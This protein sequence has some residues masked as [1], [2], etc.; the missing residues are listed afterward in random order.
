MRVCGAVLL[1]LVAACYQQPSF[2]GTY[3]TIACS[4]LGANGGQCPS[5]LTCAAALGGLYCSPMGGDPCTAPPEDAAPTDGSNRTDAGRDA[6]TTGRFVSVSAGTGYACGLTA[7]GA[8]YCWGTNTNKIISSEDATSMTFMA[9]TSVAPSNTWTQ[10]AAGA[11]HVCAIGS[12]EDLY[13]W[14]F[15]DGSDELASA[16]TG[17]FGPDAMVPVT[18]ATGWTQVSIGLGYTCGV[19]SGSAYCWGSGDNGETGGST[20]AV[21]LV[22]TNGPVAEVVGG[23]THTCAVMTSGSVS[24][25]G[26]SSDDALGSAGSGE[27]DSPVTVPGIT[28]AAHVAVTDLATCATTMDHDLYCWG[29]KSGFAFGGDTGT[30]MTPTPTPVLTGK[31]WTEIAGAETM[32]CGVANN[33]VYCWGTAAYGGLGSGSAQTG[34][35]MPIG[36]GVDHVSVGMNYDSALPAPASQYELACAITGSDTKCWG[37]NAVGA[38]GNGGSGGI[39]ST[40]TEVNGTN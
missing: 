18:A 4:S 29:S 36:S 23:E 11:D 31:T 13:C 24:C 35:Q 39:V 5:G 40:P 16:T 30:T 34:L 37:N 15:N 12:E 3:C 28:N 10:V 26:K 1:L 25:W 20:H 6:G 19:A 14:G 27:S 9:P 38:V 22:A 8:L 7:S 32:F 17:T 33:A 21:H 2:D